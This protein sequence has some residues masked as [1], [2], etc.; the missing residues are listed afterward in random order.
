MRRGWLES[1]CTLK[2]E[3]V[4]FASRLNVRLFQI[5]FP[6]KHLVWTVTRSALKTVVSTSSVSL[7]LLEISLN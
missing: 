7:S 2:T 1:G 4:G 5:I 6:S 3:P